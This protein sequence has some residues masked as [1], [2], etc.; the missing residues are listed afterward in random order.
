MVRVGRKGKNKARLAAG[1]IA[2]A[3]AP[4]DP[5]VLPQLAMLEGQVVLRQL[6]KANF[7]NESTISNT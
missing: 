1:H 3:G 2:L 4:K 5:A 7:P 6:G